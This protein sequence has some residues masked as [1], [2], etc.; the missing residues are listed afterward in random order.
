LRNYQLGENQIESFE[1]LESLRTMTKLATIYLERNPVEKLEN[2][3]Q[4]IIS[5]FPK[6]K[7]L[8]AH[9]LY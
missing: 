5:V 9:V 1:G 8:D 6:L 3:K 7:Q 2:Y 4:T